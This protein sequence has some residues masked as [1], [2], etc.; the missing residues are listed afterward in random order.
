MPPPNG[1]ENATWARY[2]FDE[3]SNLWI[4]TAHEEA[5]QWY[6]QIINREKKAIDYAQT[7]A[8]RNAMKHLLGSRR[9][10]A[11]FGTFPFCAGGRRPAQS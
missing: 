10:P 2:P 11:R 9:R 4:N 1:D 6:A 8:R 7:F 5:L 3:S